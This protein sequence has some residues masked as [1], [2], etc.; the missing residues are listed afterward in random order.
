MHHRSFTT[1][2]ITLLLILLGFTSFAQTDKSKR[3][4]P[5][6]EVSTTID[7]VKVVINYSRPSL[8]GRDLNELAPI[9]KIWRTGANEASWIS[10]EDDVK[11][12]GEK[13]PKGKYSLFTIN[14]EEVWTIIFNNVWKQWGH[15]DYN[16]A[17]DVLRVKV[18]SEK[19]NAA[20]EKFTIAFEGNETKLMWGNMV[21]PFSISKQ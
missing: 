14:E 9:G 15:Y 7:G 8:K 19:S 2:A 16:Q 3:P 20:I 10:V 4:S 11:I 17:K 18:D 5:P 6:D 21:I 12:N 1:I 13:L